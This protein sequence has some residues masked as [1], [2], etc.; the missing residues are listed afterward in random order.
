[1]VNQ[2]ND[3]LNAT[4][5]NYLV[6]SVKDYLIAL[7]H[8]DIVQIVDSP[9]WTTLPNMPH[10]FRGVI[11][12]MGGAMP[13]IDTR[14]IFSLPSLQEEV[15]EFIQTFEHRKQDHLNWVAAL[16]DCVD[17]NK[18]IA[19]ERNPH[20]CDF[21]KWYD[22][23]KPNTL[24]LKAYMRRF[25]KPHQAIHNLANRAEELTR[26]GQKATAKQ[27]I[28]DAEKDELVKLVDLFDGFEEQ[29]KRS[30]QEYA[31]VI[32]HQGIQYALAADTI[33]YFEEMDTIVKDV[34]LIGDVS[35][36][37]IH[38]IGRKKM[39][40]RNEDIIILNLDNIF[41]ANAVFQ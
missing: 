26:Q 36:K 30:Y 35:E 5:T 33:K 40:E 38:G 27:I 17:N 20:Q 28:H 29:M 18:E 41:D 19:L 6:F 3:G 13:L 10:Y 34:P 8:H 12:F 15:M 22:T 1:M 23:F 39:G 7:P 16:I 4:G 11:E 25:D 32:A 9:S 24:A 31:I 21:G 2:D 37:L 14:V